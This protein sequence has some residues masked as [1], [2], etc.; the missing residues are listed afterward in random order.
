MAGCSILGLYPVEIMH[1]FKFITLEI[2]L[3]NFWLLGMCIGPQSMDGLSASVHP[4]GK[5]K[6]IELVDFM[7]WGAVYKF[8]CLFTSSQ[9]Y[10]CIAGDY[11]VVI[12]QIIDNHKSLWLSIIWI[13]TTSYNYVIHMQCFTRFKL[14]ILRECSLLAGSKTGVWKN[15]LWVVLSLMCAL[16]SGSGAGM[17]MI[18]CMVLLQQYFNRRRALASGIGTLGF[19]VGGLTFGPL[20]TVLLEVYAVRGT[21]LIIGALN[22]QLSVFCCLFRPAPSQCHGVIET[23]SANNAHGKEEVVVNVRNVKFDASSELQQSGEQTA[24]QSFSVTENDRHPRSCA[25]R[26]RSWLGQVFADMFDFS[27][28]RCVHFQL[29]IAATI[30]VFFGVTSFVQHT[31]SR[32]AHFGVEP[33]LISVLPTL[34]CAAVIASRLVFSFVANLKCT[35]LTLQFAIFAALGGFV[36]VSMWLTTTF[37]TMTLFCILQGTAFGEW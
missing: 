32:A 30:C 10:R 21:L 4:K 31:P 2:D 6:A 9:W 20:I 27:L 24:K 3:P 17:M 25:A 22:F 36:H 13:I 28:L 8:S 11:S 14:Y 33:W 19:S 18:S 26:L 12:I 16:L 35:H 34:I 1:S 5:G 29:F 37:E 7:F 15:E 23:K